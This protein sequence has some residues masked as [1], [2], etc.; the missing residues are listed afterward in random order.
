MIRDSPQDERREK[1][2][3]YM[4]SRFIRDLSVD[5]AAEESGKKEE[6]KGEDSG[7]L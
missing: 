6:G 2:V 5:S 4:L 1:I 7:V 3:G